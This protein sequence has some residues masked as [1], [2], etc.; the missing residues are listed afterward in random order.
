MARR[1]VKLTIDPQRPNFANFFFLII[2]L[3]HRF[4]V[5]WKNKLKSFNDRKISGKNYFGEELI[6]KN[7]SVGLKLQTFAYF[8]YIASCAVSRCLGRWYRG[9]FSCRI[10]EN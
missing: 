3:Q 2:Q 8:V 6:N 4:T 5:W 10:R 1:L 7:L 9:F